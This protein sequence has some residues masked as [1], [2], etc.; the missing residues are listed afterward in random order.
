MDNYF[1]LDNLPVGKS[2]TINSL[3]FKGLE[4]QRIMNLGLIKGTKIK[5][6]QK[7][8]IGDPTA[9]AFKGTIIALRASDA[10]KI[11]IKH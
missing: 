2:A 4:R 8:P 7:S 1:S 9:Y 11:I 5:V 6:V 10:K 3:L